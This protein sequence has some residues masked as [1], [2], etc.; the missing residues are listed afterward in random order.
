MLVTK[1]LVTKIHPSSISLYNR[2]ISFHEFFKENFCF[3]IK[4]NCF[5]FHT[6]LFRNVFTKS[7][8]EGIE[9]VLRENGD[10]AFLMESTIVEYVVERKC[11]LTQIGGLLDS[12]GYGIGLPPSK[13]YNNFENKNF[14]GKFFLE[15]IFPHSHK[16][17]IPFFY[18]TFSKCTHFGKCQWTQP[19]LVQRS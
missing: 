14:F 18:I 12:K 15:G 9:R 3:F 6:Y 19:F 16:Q 13:K 11:E 17:Q 7:N 1:L 5:V 10:Y 4:N 8:K 2:V